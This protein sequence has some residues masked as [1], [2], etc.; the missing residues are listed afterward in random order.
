MGYD[1]VKDILGVLIIIIHLQIVGKCDVTNISRKQLTQHGV[2]SGGQRAPREG[3]WLPLS[4]QLSHSVQWD[5][6]SI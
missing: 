6:I 5:S 4:V 3:T 1:L 2:E